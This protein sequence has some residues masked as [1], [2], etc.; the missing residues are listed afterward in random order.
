MAKEK[1]MVLG[2]GCAAMAAVFGITDRAG[3]QDQYDITVYQPGWR[4]GGKGAAGRNAAAGDRIEEH[5][6]HVWSGFY[7]NA[8]WIMRKVYNALKRPAVDPLSSTFTAFRPHHYAGLSDYANGDWVF[9]KGYLPHAGGLPGDFIDPATIITK[10]RVNK[11][12]PSNNKAKESEEAAAQYITEAI[13]KPVIA[14]IAGRHAPTTQNWQET[15]T[16]AS[17]IGRSANFGTAESKLA[18]FKSAKIP[19]ADSPS[20]I[21]KLLKNILTPQ[22]VKTK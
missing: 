14:Y 10:V 9:W 7:E 22:R 4:L 19:V 13:D 16:L 12:T 15:G 2:G 17:V 6:L 21:P 20:Q 1:L 3:W 11:I 5:G 18:A 8:F